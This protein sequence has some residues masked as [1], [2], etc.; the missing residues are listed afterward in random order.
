M[1]YRKV[2]FFRKSTVKMYNIR[3]FDSRCNP[4]AKNQKKGRKQLIIKRIYLID[5][6]NKI[7]GV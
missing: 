7:N 6:E 4:R 2:T 3:N 1:Y 5:T